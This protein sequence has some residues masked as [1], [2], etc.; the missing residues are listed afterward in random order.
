M[1]IRAFSGG[2]TSPKRIA[3]SI[4]R[5]RCNPESPQRPYQ[6]R[7]CRHVLI[8]LIFLAVVVLFHERADYEF[9][10]GRTT[11]TEI[12]KGGKEGFD[13]KKEFILSTTPASAVEKADNGGIT[14]SA[15]AVTENMSPLFHM[16]FS[17]GDDTLTTLNLRSIESIFFFHPDA[18]LIIHTRS[19][20]G[21]S[22]TSL[23]QLQP[24]MEEG[25]DIT[26]VRY[27]PEISLQAVI[28][29]PE[30]GV[31]RRAAAEFIAKLPTLSQEKYWYSNETNLLRMCLL[32]L[33]GGIYMDTD[34]LI[35]SKLVN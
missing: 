14:Q 11:L 17:T 6:N 33:H 20:G 16:I 9:S 13:G 12:P 18:R 35:S 28:D 5:V 27:I 7:G 8:F 1:T 4:G 10:N 25:F 30:S 32:F 21:L 3:S 2:L 15:A 31:D 26:L 34:V 29:L 24:L 19:N 22:S 23:D